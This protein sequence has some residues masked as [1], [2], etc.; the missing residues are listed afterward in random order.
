MKQAQIDRCL[1]AVR[2]WAEAKVASGREPPWAWY[3]YMK[4]IEAVDA[5][6]IGRSRVTPISGDSRGKASRA[7]SARPEAGEVV[8]LDTPRRRPRKKPPPLPM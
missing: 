5:I 8:E 7:R 1:G 2:G 3:Q 6:Q 4:L